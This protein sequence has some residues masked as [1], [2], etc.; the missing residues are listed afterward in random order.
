MH[1]GTWSKGEKRAAQQAF[2][3]ALARENAAL[4]EEVRRRAS[5]LTDVKEVWKLNEYLNRK[6]RQMN[7]K[8]DYRYSQMVFVLARL[9]GEGWLTEEDLEGLGEVRKA[10]I[11]FL[12]RAPHPLGDEADE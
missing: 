7:E 3:A 1:N 5:Q 8:Y 4:V 12:G 6:S 10:Q 9:L 11:L 2:N